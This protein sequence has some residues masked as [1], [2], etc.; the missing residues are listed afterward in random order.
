MNKLQEFVAYNLA[1]QGRKRLVLGVCLGLWALFELAMG[2][3]FYALFLVA[4][5]IALVTVRPPSAL[6]LALPVLVI[7]LFS[8]PTLDAWIKLRQSGLSAT[9]PKQPLANI[10]SP[11]TGQEVLSPLVRQML[12]LLRTNH[13]ASYGLSE[14]FGQD[15]TIEQRIVESAWPIRIDNASN[16]ILVSA[17]EIRL[18]PACSVIDQRDGGGYGVALEHCR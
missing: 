1:Q 7:V 5:F 14:R 16:Y 4:F 9:R 15:Y 3:V 6:F 12:S 17:K 13:I 8:T 10:F 2:N 11:N 18:Y